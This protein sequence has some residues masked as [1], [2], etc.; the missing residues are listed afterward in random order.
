MTMLPSTLKVIVLPLHK[1][2]LNV[3]STVE[4]IVTG[5]RLKIKLLVLEMELNALVK[6]MVPEPAQD[7]TV[8]VN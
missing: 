5:C 3:D 7:G 8:A 4:L 6:V 1:A 2:L